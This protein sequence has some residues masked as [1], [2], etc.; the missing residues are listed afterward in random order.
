MTALW[1]PH[2]YYNQWRQRADEQVNEI[3]HEVRVPTFLNLGDQ[4][5]FSTLIQSSQVVSGHQNQRQ[6]LSVRSLNLNLIVY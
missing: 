6:S 5:C 1:G 4:P 2:G 3:T